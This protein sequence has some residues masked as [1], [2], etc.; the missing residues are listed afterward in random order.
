MSAYDQIK[1][2]PRHGNEFE[3]VFLSS[4]H[5]NAAFLEYFQEMKWPAIPFER[6]AIIQQLGEKYEIKAIPSIVILNENGEVVDKDGRNTLAPKND[7]EAIF[8][9]WS[10]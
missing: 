2:N 1:E 3:I 9:K 5:D 7:V 10:L 8:E 6:S 4:D